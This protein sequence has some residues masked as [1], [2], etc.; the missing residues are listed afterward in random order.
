MRLIEFVEVWDFYESFHPSTSSGR[1]SFLPDLLGLTHLP[2]LIKGL[3][4]VLYFI[5]QVSDDE[6][7][8][9]ALGCQV[10]AR[11]VRASIPAVR[12]W[13]SFSLIQSLNLL[14]SHLI[15]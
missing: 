4:H 9:L 10:I 3:P 15:Y 2:S 7:C 1:L 13:F 12:L 5:R 11:M 6:S 8:Q 14:T